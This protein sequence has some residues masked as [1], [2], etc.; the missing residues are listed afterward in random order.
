[1]I[2]QAGYEIS[3]VDSFQFDKRQS[4]EF[5]EVYKG[6]VPEYPDQ[7]IEFCSGL[8]VCLEVTPNLSTLAPN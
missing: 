4:E 6:V 5:L 1:M 8:A 3:A 2:V 7:V